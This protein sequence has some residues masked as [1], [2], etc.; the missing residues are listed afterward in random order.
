MKKKD[1][2]QYRL[3]PYSVEGLSIACSE[4]IDWGL[5]A[6]NIPDAWKEAYGNGIKVAVLDTGASLKHP[7]LEGQI[8]KAKDFT[9]S[10]SGPYDT[11]GHGTHCAGVVAGNKNDSGIIG[12]APGCKLL[13]GKVL[14]D[15]GAGN[16][17]GISEGIRWAADSDADIISM[18][19]GSSVKDKAITASI[20]YAY[21]K[22][23][24]LVSAAGN[25]G[26]R[27][28]TTNYP[29]NLDECI[30]VA[31]VDKDSLAAKFSSRGKVNIAAPGVDIT[32][33]WPPKGY[34]KLSGTSMATPFVAGVLALVLSALKAENIK[35]KSLI[36]KITETFYKTA[37]DAGKSGL[38]TSYGWGL[39]EP[40]SAI[41]EAKKI[42]SSSK[43]ATNNK[44]E[45]IVISSSDFTKDGLEKLISFVKKICDN[46]SL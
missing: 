2:T 36:S 18:S 17:K 32:S 28:G 12:V 19:F 24:Y 10:T 13:I 34:A 25:E 8:L 45:R 29:A 1:K 30:S 43:A 6:C 11:N 3:P 15:E 27:E 22:G 41:K 20:K 37:V 38:D 4:T 16:S 35:Y 31:A 42:T 46:Q 44:P 7:D 14:D 9:G 39:I 21:S 5:R 23:C 33:C 26:P 40:R